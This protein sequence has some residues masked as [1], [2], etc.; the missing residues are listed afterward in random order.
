[1]HG[2]REGSW[3]EEAFKGWEDMH[4]WKD[5]LE[6]GAGLR[7]GE[8][9]PHSSGQAHFDSG[10]RRSQGGWQKQQFVGK[11]CGLGRGVDMRACGCRG[12]GWPSSALAG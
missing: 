3:E 2:I 5:R 11:H 6:A 8:G 9:A 12:S 4:G 10:D 7:G 1:M